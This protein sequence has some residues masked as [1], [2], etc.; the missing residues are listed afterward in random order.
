M[1]TVRSALPIRSLPSKL[2]MMYLASW[3]RHAARSF[4]MIATFFVCDCGIREFRPLPEESKR[5]EPS[6]RCS[7]RC[8][9]DG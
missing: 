1:I 7:S 3:S 2:R 9:S 6:A 8:P 5:H 4:E